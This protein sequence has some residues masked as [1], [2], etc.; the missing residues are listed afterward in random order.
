MF[1][2]FFI[3]LAFTISL[4]S[5]LC[6]MNKASRSL[7]EATERGDTKTVMELLQDSHTNINATVGYYKHTPL[8]IAA[9][10]GHREIVQHLLS[11][12]A[13][14]LITATDYGGRTAFYRAAEGGHLDILKDLLNSISGRQVLAQI[15]LAD[16]VHKMTPL[17]IA[18]QKGHLE[19]V[20][21][22]LTLPGINVNAQDN[23]R[24]TALIEALYARN[25][26]EIVQELLKRKDL[27]VS[28]TD[29]NGKSALDL[30]KQ[31][32]DLAKES[33]EN[34]AVVSLLASDPRSYYQRVVQH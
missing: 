14:I 3:P 6:A 20:K 18:A 17:M 21:F 27:N 26:A 31:R 12:E 1:T 7:H 33:G 13:I 28:A 10:K 5:S 4:G 25:S 24:R 11:Q 29:A 34:Q 23:F 16:K 22:L 19:V 8:M 2:K 30:A 32:L 15:N 9:D